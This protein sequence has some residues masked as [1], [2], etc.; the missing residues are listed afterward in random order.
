M[1]TFLVVYWSVSHIH[2]TKSPTIVCATMAN[3]ADFKKIIKNSN[4]N[5]FHKFHF[6]LLPRIL[7][8]QRWWVV[9]IFTVAF[10]DN[11]PSYSSTIWQT[12]PILKTIPLRSNELISRSQTKGGQSG[13]TG[14]IRWRL[15]WWR[16][17]PGSQ[18]V[19]GWY[20]TIFCY[21]VSSIEPDESQDYM[22]NSALL[23]GGPGFMSLPPPTTLPLCPPWS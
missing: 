1:K 17:A 2:L 23:S 20:F 7:L 19:W 6:R 4:Q 3:Y 12:L 14:C 9:M 5:A 22:E 18:A 8:Y 16:K 21:Q 10:A 13:Q 11:H 15:S